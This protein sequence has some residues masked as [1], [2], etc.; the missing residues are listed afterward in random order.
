MISPQL[1]AEV[2][3]YGELWQSTEFHIWSPSPLNQEL[4]S[5]T[6]NKRR[7]IIIIS[8]VYAFTSRK[9]E[10]INKRGC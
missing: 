8:M 7:K 4:L 10:T 1:V 6:K 3:E 2:L 9:L 5:F